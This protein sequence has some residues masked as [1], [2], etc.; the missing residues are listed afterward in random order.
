MNEINNAILEALPDL[1]LVVRSDGVIVGN[2]GGRHLGIA[3]EP[4]ELIGTSLREVW[5]EDIAGHLNLLVRRTLR[6]RMPV[7]RHYAYQDRSYE[8]RVQPQGVDRVLMVLRDVTRDASRTTSM[9]LMDEPASTL[10]EHRAAF[11]K[12]LGTAVSNCQLRETPLALAA[13]HLGGLRDARNHLGPAACGRLLGNVLKGL[14]SP[15]PLPGDT[16]PHVSPFGR[17]RS[18]LLVVLF[19]GMP[20]RKSVAEAADRIR[21]ALAEPLVDGDKSAQLRP[22]L[23]LAQFSNDGAT[24]QVLLESARAALAAA[25]QSDHD[26]TVVFCTRTMQIPVVD[27]PDFEQE[28][29]WAL[30]HG[31]L[32]LHYQPVLD[33]VSR[34]VLSYEALIRWL[35]PVCGEMV[36]E[37]FLHV[38]E[39][40]PLGAVI[41]EWALRRAC[42]DLPALGRSADWPARV[43]VNFGCRM[44]EVQQLGDKLT[45]CT[46]AAGIALGQIDVN[47]S[48]RIMS[49]AGSRLDRLRELRERG[50][51]VFVYGFG[52]GRI[53]LDRLSSLPI[54]GIGIDRAFIARI[55][56]DAGARAMCQ[57]VVSIARAFGLR[58]IAVG[59]EKQGQLDFLSGIGCEAVQG[60]FLCA[61]LSLDNFDAMHDRPKAA[62]AGGR[63]I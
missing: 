10:I 56:Y 22:T 3:D 63:R 17:I 59:V 50:V 62:A 29:R 42:R 34:R 18:D 1:T 58:S 51:K 32:A 14:Q 25:R 55:E 7:D 38:A 27:L 35:H 49:T 15:A 2:V 52:T 54:D 26:S 4:G 45:S 20:D 43:A 28:L 5:T 39:H 46:G 9:K 37:Q 60:R 23:G 8:V 57:S 48:E 47:I 21:R 44:L 36:P 41:D 30:E 16:P 12:R 11:E 13:I 53:A 6:T 31:Q 24:P 19:F 40:S 61:P 33:L